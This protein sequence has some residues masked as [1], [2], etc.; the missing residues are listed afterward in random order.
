MFSHTAA[1]FP[2]YHFLTIPIFFQIAGLAL[3]SPFPLICSFASVCV[4]ICRH[5]SK[6]VKKALVSSA[7]AHADQSPAGV[8]LCDRG[9]SWSVDHCV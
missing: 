6:N 2:H 9:T 7:A 4:N 1:V 3:P 5:V 8:C